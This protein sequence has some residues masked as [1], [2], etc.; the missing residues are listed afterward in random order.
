MV[1]PYTGIYLMGCVATLKLYLNTVKSDKYLYYDE[2][3]L[4]INYGTVATKIFRVL[5][6]NG[7]SIK[8]YTFDGAETIDPEEARWF[9]VTDPNMMILLDD[10]EDEI[11]MNKNATLSLD[12]YG[13]CLVQIKQIASH[14]ILNFTMRNFG[15]EVK[16]KE[17]SYMAKKK[18]KEQ[19]KLKQVQESSFSKL[20]GSQKT[21][22][23][24]LEGVKIV[25]KHFESVSDDKRGDRSRKIK[26]I[27]IEHNGERQK[28]PVANL[29]CARAMARHVQHGGTFTDVLGEHIVQTTLKLKDLVEFSKYTKKSNMVNEQTSEIMDMVREGIYSMMGDLESISK[30][31][32]YMSSKCRIESNQAICEQEDTMDIKQMFTSEQIDSRVEKVL[33]TLGEMMSANKQKMIRIQEASLNTI[34]CDRIISE[35]VGIEYSSKKIK[36]GNDLLDISSNIVE[37]AELS[38]YI[39]KIGEKLISEGTI[40]DFEKQIV[41]NVFENLTVKPQGEVIETVMTSFEDKFM[42]NMTESLKSMEMKLFEGIGDTQFEGYSVEEAEDDSND[43]DLGPLRGSVNGEAS[44]TEYRAILQLKNRYNTPIVNVQQNIKGN[45]HATGGGWGLDTLNDKMSDSIWIDYGQNWRIDAGMKAAIMKANE[46]VNSQDQNTSKVDEAGQYT[47]NAWSQGINDDPEYQFYVL[48]KTDDGSKIHSGW[49]YRED[50]KE[51]LEQTEQDGT[52]ANRRMVSRYGVDPKTDKD[53]L[54]ADSH[55]AWVGSASNNIEEDA[56]DEDDDDE[57]DKYSGWEY[58]DF[59]IAKEFPPAIVNGDTSGLNSREERALNQFLSDDIFQ[60][61]GHWEFD[62]EYSED[63]CIDDV[64]GKHADCVAAKWLVKND[65]MEGSDDSDDQR[66]LGSLIHDILNVNVGKEGADKFTFDD[67]AMKDLHDLYQGSQDERNGVTDGQLMRQADKV[68]QSCRNGHGEGLDIDDRGAIVIAED[69]HFMEDMDVIS[70]EELNAEFRDL[71]PRLKH[72][73]DVV[74]N[75][76]TIEEWK[77]DKSQIELSP[78]VKQ[79]IMRELETAVFRYHAARQGLGIAN[80]LKDDP[81][82]MKHKRRVMSNL[83]ALRAFVQKLER[84]LKIQH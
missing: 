46:I 63:F 33:P 6:G 5:K 49:E 13:T 82:R 21:S 54:S 12:V 74:K 68:L 31:N 37:N 17:F 58:W 53:W 79:K 15:K 77:Y 7:Y 39:V 36:L 29:R 35:N 23:Q 40:T 38:G 34:Y 76:D 66:P 43:I 61:A 75:A 14:Y 48:V 22:I 20:R 84:L 71:G 28:L 10:A 27:F 59:K 26:D 47:D 9:Y 83:N 2:S 69:E 11:K 72:I 42:S 60:K 25:V 16:P 24:A 52:I 18:K 57:Q 65:M 51:A 64:T 4:M 45:W 67:E 73:I 62:D 32:S 8:T 19:D 81:S 80:K 70:D 41:K 56:D 44:N 78:S 50:A 1:P 3:L 55:A 30:S